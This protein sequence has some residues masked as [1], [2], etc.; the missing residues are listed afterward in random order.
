MRQRLKLGLAFYTQA[1]V[2]FFDEPG[3]NLDKRA[4]EWYKH[5]FENLSKEAVILIAS[6]DPAEYP[7]SATVLNIMDF[8]R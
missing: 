7:E 8:K 1:D 3:T 5:E 2:Y 4:F 6:N